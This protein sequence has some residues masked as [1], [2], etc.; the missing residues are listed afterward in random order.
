M[1]GDM[2]KCEQP[3]LLVWGRVK[4]FFYFKISIMIF[5]HV[6]NKQRYILFKA[7]LKPHLQRDSWSTR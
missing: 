1:K 2:K 5:I 6:Y 4:L 3:D 7:L